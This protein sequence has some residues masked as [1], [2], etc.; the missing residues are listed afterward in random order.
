MFSKTGNINKTINKDVFIGH[1]SVEKILFTIAFI[2]ILLISL[3][4]F[5]TP[6]ATEY[7]LSIYYAYP[8]YFWGLAVTAISCGIGILIRQAFTVNKSLWWLGGLL[9]VIITNSIVLGLPFFRGYTFFPA[10]D[11]MSHIGIMK[12]I[13]L[14]GHFGSNNFYPILHILG[15][16]L[17]NISG[18]ADNVVVNILVILWN[19]VFLFGIYLLSSVLANRKGQALLITTFACPLI[20]SNLHTLIHPSMISIYLLPLLLYFY[21]RD[22]LL[23]NHKIAN[24]ISL[25]LLAI[26]ITFT[27]PVTSLFAIIMILTLNTSL[28]AYRRLF[29]VSGNI[30]NNIFNN[31]SNFNILLIMIV[32]YGAWYLTFVWIQNDIKSVYDFFTASGSNESLLTHQTARLSIFG[33]SKGQTIIL[34]FY[35][36]GVILLYSFVSIMV[37]INLT[38]T[39]MRHR[40]L[41]NISFGLSVLFIVA[42]GFSLFS[43]IGFTGEYEPIRIARF[44]LLVA[45]MLMGQVIYLVITNNHK[46]VNFSEMGLKSKLYLGIISIVIMIAG[47][48][49]IFNVYSSPW[50]MTGNWQVSNMDIEGTKWFFH[51]QI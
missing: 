47:C 29:K 6:H 27:H 36:Y 32:V 45:P 41:S 46:F 44:F 49:S 11:A 31:R 38:I 4:I 13:V 26:L 35:K 24:K 42:T 17:L 20:F 22:L 16:C 28:M 30:A 1:T 2:C 10:G 19:I 18:L 8:F 5:F 7:E 48:L 12:D 43:L 3:V 21:Y 39:T 14:T 25:I 15:V 51:P 9:I 33:I 23:N 37:L 50:T 34:I 40:T